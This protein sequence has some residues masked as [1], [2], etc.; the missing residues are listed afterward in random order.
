[1][2]HTKNMAA[3]PQL[4]TV[5]QFRQLPEGGEYAYELHSGEVVA[6][7]RPKPRYWML[8]KR[9]S[10][11][12]EQ[13]LNEFGE[14]VIELPYRAVAEYDLRAADVA[15]ISHARY[16]AIDPEVDLRG[17]PE[18]VIEVKS[19]SNTPRQLQ[20]IAALCL[21]SGAFEFWVVDPDACSVSVGSNGASVVVYSRGASIPLTAF[22]AD[23]LAVSE[24]FA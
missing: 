7:T 10:R 12:L 8:Q 23:E 22:A 17:A 13:K 2:W 11:L 3:L 4:I 20:Q 18:L 24:I 5:E 21:A 6:L 19:P 16:A 14:V 9:L 15:V 1:L